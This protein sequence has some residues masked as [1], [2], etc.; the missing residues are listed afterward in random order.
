[1][2]SNRFLNA[3]AAV[4]AVA[5]ICVVSE[6]SA[7]SVPGNSPGDSDTT[8]SQAGSSVVDSQVGATAIGSF[9][10]GVAAQIS[11]FGGNLGPLIQV[12]YLPEDIGGQ[13][14][15]AA[16]FEPS[17][18]AGWANFSATNIEED[19]VATRYKGDLRT[20]MIGAD[21]QYDDKLLAGVALGMD[22]GEINTQFNGGTVD[23]NTNIISSYGSYRFDDMFSVDGIIG[24]GRGD[25][26]QVRFV[27]ATAVNS[28]TTYDRFFGQV[29]G[30]AVTTV[31]E[32]ENAVLAGQVGLLY[33]LE[34]VDDFVEDNGT[35]VTGRTNPLTQAQI[36]LRG[37]YSF[38]DIA[39]NWVIHPYGHARY[40]VDLQSNTIDVGAGQAAHPNDDKEVQLALGVDFYAGADLSGNFEYSRSFGRRD[41]TSDV[42]SL[43]LRLKFGPGE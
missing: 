38:F 43:N 6:A 19:V 22:R 35:N 24:Y 13:W 8:E 26:E 7:Q 36:G 9:I 11:R 2:K 18:L 5:A 40:L 28:D 41:F 12:G 31:P 23:T 42:F 3:L 25:I 4:F 20:Y 32:V 27:G 39:E 37:G 15:R 29:T 1:M 16:G 34:R 14:G 10:T 17:R 33:A 21:Y 30:N